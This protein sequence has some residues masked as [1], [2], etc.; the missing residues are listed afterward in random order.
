MSDTPQRPRRTLILT[1][2]LIAGTLGLW[3]LS[4]KDSGNGQTGQPWASLLTPIQRLDPLAPIPNPR[5]PAEKTVNGAKAEA[6]RGVFYDASYHS[7]E[8]PGG[9]V[10]PDR[11]ACTDVVVRSLRAAGYDL[12]RLIHEDMRRNFR[13]YPQRYGLSRPDRNIDHRRTP[14][15]ITFFRRHGL[16]L[17][18][19]ITGEAAKAW[20]PGDLVYCRLSNG[21]GHCGVVSDVRGW[22]GLPLVIHNMGLTRQEDVLGSWEITDHFRYPLPSRRPG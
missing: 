2:I 10:P 22:S 11:G 18:T 12:Q 8:Y 9:D 3:A 15:H 14:N 1:G 6:R 13:R 7:L 19:Q 17:T 16:V 21:M 5:T 4:P 20:Q